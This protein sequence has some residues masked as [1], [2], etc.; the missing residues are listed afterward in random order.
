ML[1]FDVRRWTSKAASKGIALVL[2]LLKT[3]KISPQGGGRLGWISVFQGALLHVSAVF[4]TDQWREMC[5]AGTLRFPKAHLLFPVTSTDTP[6][7]IRGSFL[8]VTALCKSCFNKKKFN[9]NIY[10]SSLKQD[11]DNSKYPKQDRIQVDKRAAAALPLPVVH[12]P[13]EI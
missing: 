11:T 5:W 4:Y 6:V 2:V 1:L 10:R 12:N 9:P 13:T 7:L 3:I 8:C